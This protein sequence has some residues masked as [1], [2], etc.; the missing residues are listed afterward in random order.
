[1]M[2]NKEKKKLKVS[3]LIS[4]DITDNGFS[5]AGYKGYLKIRDLLPVE[6][7][8][9]F[10]LAG[11]I[12]QA[13]LT[14]ELR[15]LAQ[16]GPDLIIGHGGQFDVPAQTIEKEFPD[17]KF[18]V[19]QGN[20]TGKNISNYVVK[21]EDS[22]WL[23]GV[24]A[25]FMTKSNIVGHIS[26]ARPKSLLIERAAFYD[27]LMYA[28]PGAKFLTCFTGNM[29]DPEINRKAAEAEIAKG[30][31]I[32]YTSLNIGRVG[33]TETVK[34]TN[35]KVSHIGNVSDWTLVDKSFIASA[36]ANPSVAVFKAASDVLFEKW[37]GND[38]V[39][40]GLDNVEVVRLSMGA[41]VPEYV[42]EKIAELTKKLVSGEIIS[43]VVYKGK[44]F[45]PS[46]GELE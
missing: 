20:T 21:Q 17:I 32:I 15:K 8:C 40:I 12:D 7:K 35:G 31:D 22:T 45:N 2:N 42:K 23:A 1:M 43:N 46:T 44:E 26:G 30:A 11:T 5:E 29:K 14:E 41:A 4:G 9:V 39:E 24:L 28:N 27:G 3:I 16:E 37:E 33:V 25:G 6:V 36:V 38:T 19:I 34:K 10:N 18:T 13:V